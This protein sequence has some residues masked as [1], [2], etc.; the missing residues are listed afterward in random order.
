MKLKNLVEEDFVNYK[1]P[2]MFLIT[3]KCDFKCCKEAGNTI[4]Q[5]MDIIKY[6]DHEINNAVLLEKFRD[7][8]ITRAFVIGGLEPMDTF[9]DVLEFV[10]FVR[11]YSVMSPIV[12]YTGYNKDEIIDKVEKLSQWPNIIIKY[13][14]FIPGQES[15]FDEVLGVYLAS[16]NQYAEELICER[17]ESN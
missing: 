14:R 12:I 17:L 9:E 16:P 13:G 7:N 4:C 6:P 5:N 1:L 11:F 3:T 2:S 15:H 10:E 8:P